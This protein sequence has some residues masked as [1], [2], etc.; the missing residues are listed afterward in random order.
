MEA[1]PLL[2]RRRLPVRV[3]MEA[4]EEGV[5][6]R[7]GPQKQ[8]EKPAEQQIRIFLLEVAVAHLEQ[9]ELPE[10]R[11][12]MVTQPMACTVARAVEEEEAR[13]IVLSMVG[14]VGRVDF[15]VV[16]AAAVV[17]RYRAEQQ[18]EEQVETEVAV[19]CM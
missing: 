9:L 15:Q 18:S 8:R 17:L 6:D 14:L 10:H 7:V 4:Q 11:A 1:V 19:L 12:L 13:P 3:F 16:V 5:V 2:E